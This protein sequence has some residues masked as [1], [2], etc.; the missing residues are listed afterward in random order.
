MKQRHHITYKPAWI[1]E[2]TGWQ[3]KVITYIQRLKPTRTNYAAV[4]NF[5]HAVCHEWQRLR[6]QLDEIEKRNENP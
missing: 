4:T 2:L 6:Y 3:H 1:V 5:M